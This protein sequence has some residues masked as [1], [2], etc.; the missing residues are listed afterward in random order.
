MKQADEL[1][2]GSDVKWLVHLMGDMHQPPT[3]G[4]S[5]GRKIADRL[6]ADYTALDSSS[7]P[8]IVH[9]F[10]LTEPVGW[11]CGASA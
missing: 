4:S 9:D 2:T 10:K 7:R 1:E 8:A 6:F 5:N 11:H 3:F